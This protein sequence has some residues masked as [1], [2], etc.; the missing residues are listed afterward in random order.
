MSKTLPLG[1]AR[2]VRALV[3]VLVPPVKEF[4]D[5]GIE[6]TVVRDMGRMV[7]E[8]Q[9]FSRWGLLLGIALFEWFP[10]LS[11]FGFVR[12]SNLSLE[13]RA[14]YVREWAESRFLA[15]REFFKALKGMIIMIYF[16][17]KRVWAYL[18]YNPVPHMEEKIKLREEIIA[19][20]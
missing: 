14:R 1:T 9:K 15:K 8:F 3:H 5:E 13:S 6:E 12:F 10:F 20:S 11:G 4:S 16:S 2:V 17:D 7:F 18:D 19:R